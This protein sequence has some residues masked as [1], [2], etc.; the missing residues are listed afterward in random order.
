MAI[1]FRNTRDFT[2]MRRVVRRSE[3]KRRK[4]RRQGRQWPIGGAGGGGGGATAPFCVFRYICEN[5]QNVEYWS[6]VTNGVYS[7]WVKTEDETP[8]DYVPNPEAT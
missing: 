6:E 2:R 3:A 1:A 8:P 7:D 5:G 4:L